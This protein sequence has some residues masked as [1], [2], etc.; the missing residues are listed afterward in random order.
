MFSKYTIIFDILMI[1]KS[2][3]FSYY[4]R[5]KILNRKR[6]EYLI[7]WGILSENCIP[8]DGTIPIIGSSN[9]MGINMSSRDYL[10][11]IPRI[12]LERSVSFGKIMKS[13]EVL[14]SVP[15]KEIYLYR[16]ISRSCRWS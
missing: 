13:I 1:S 2:E 3:Y 4:M 6:R 16:V 12:T 7:S 15:T 11:N 14:E 9:I 8:I 10:N 5:R